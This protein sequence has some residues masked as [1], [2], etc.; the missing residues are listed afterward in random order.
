MLPRFQWS[1]I[2]TVGHYLGMLVVM[3]GMLMLIPLAVAVVFDEGAS[4]SAFMFGAGLCL[5]LGA[6]LQML[7]AYVIDRRRS[8]ILTGLSW[9]VVGCFAAV[10]LYCGGDFNS[11]FDAVFDAVSALTTTGASQA[12]DLDHLARS[13]V[14]WRALLAL[15]GG[16]AAIVIAL[17]FGVG[18]GDGNASF[19]SWHRM[20]NGE[21]G[22][23]SVEIGRAVAL[24]AMFYM[25]IGV[26][27]AFFLGLWIGFGPVDAA[28]HGFW[29]IANALSTGG[30]VPYSADLAYY[31]S[32]P[33]QA[34]LT[35]FM[36]LGATNFGIFL[37]ALRGKY[38]SI[39]RNTE[40]KMYLLWIVAL[41]LF[42]TFCLT[43]DQL[44]TSLAGLYSNGVFSV[45]SMAT[46]S[47][48]QV[49]PSAQ[50]GQ[51]VSDGILMI[52]MVG[53]LFGACSHASGGGIKSIRILQVLRWIAFAILQRLMPDSARVRIHYEHFGTRSLTADDAMSAMTICILYVV[54]A[55]LGSMAFIAHGNDAL[56]SVFESVSYVSNCGATAG[57]SGPGMS[58]D[59]KI[60]AFLLMWAGR[61]EFIALIAVIAGAAMS[62][63]PVR[64]M[65]RLSGGRLG[66]RKKGGGIAWK[67]RKDQ[68]RT[69]RASDSHRNGVLPIIL[70]VMLLCAAG[71]PV[72]VAAS[73]SESVSGS[74]EE[75]QVPAAEIPSLSSTK[76]YRE[77]SVSGLLSASERLDGE[78]VSFEGE[79]IG[80]PLNNDPGYKWVNIAQDGAMVGVRL[81]D[82]Q[83][84][85]ISAYGSYG[86][87]GDTVRVEGSYNLDCPSHGGQIDVHADSV[88]VLS[89]GSS[90]QRGMSLELV[91]AGALL[92]V[93]SIVLSIVRFR[94]LKQRKGR[95][96]RQELL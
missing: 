52:L 10:P 51:I 18:G 81:S 86:H 84:S 78:T 46:T 88:S 68:S 42:V 49:V 20:G 83:A 22:G 8:L 65:N 36:I 48:M 79:A 93:L 41:V 90:W 77:V 16:Q 19:S 12:N 80:E 17:Y 91:V 29:L 50:F 30:F 23:R 47:G 70:S 43:R 11:F 9:F 2:S 14:T 92:M 61:M 37:Y 4:V 82:E 25:L 34:Y 94:F 96:K 57:L 74:L 24:V 71:S 32:V 45:I 89:E 33:L 44:V 53:I 73:S 27:G 95:V 58:L 15:A 72:A 3:T 67:K 75:G 76:T 54:A 6:V 35:I 85:A 39:L 87:T 66:R 59:L 69:K 21:G 62:L 40:L 13:Q 60:I 38:K 63:N 31:H 56:K 1:D 26:I 5:G 28:F 55:A 64:I 7:P